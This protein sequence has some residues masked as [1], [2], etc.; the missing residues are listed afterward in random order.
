[1]PPKSRAKGRAAPKAAPDRPLPDVPVTIPAHWSSTEGINM[2]PDHVMIDKFQKLI[3]HTWRVKYTRD[4]KHGA[5]SDKCPTGAR[6][7]NVLRVE[8]HPNFQQYCN[9][10]AAIREKR[11]AEGGCPNF[12]VKTDDLL[13]PLEDDVNAMYLFH[14]TNPIAA[15]AIA[16]TDFRIDLAGSA[17]GCMF[18]P[19]LYL[20]ENA[21]KSDEYAKEGDG[22]FM[23][24]CALLVCRAVAGKV[25]TTQDKGNYQDKVLSGEFDSVCGDRLAAVGTF[26][27]MIFFG[28]A[29]VYTEYIVLYTRLF[30]E[31]P[32]K[33][34]ALAPAAV[35]APV[36]AP[37][38]PVAAAPAAPASAPAPAPAPAFPAST[39]SPTLP[40]LLAK[41]LAKIE[42]GVPYRIRLHTDQDGAE[43]QQ[44]LN[45]GKKR[46][47][48]SFFLHAVSQDPH[49]A[50]LWEF[51]EGQLEGSFNI[52]LKSDH[53]AKG[54]FMEAHRFKYGE[55]KY[56]DSTFAMCHRSVQGEKHA[57]ICRGDW[58]LEPTGVLGSF[59]LTLKSNHVNGSQG[60]CLD[61]R[62]IDKFKKDDTSCWVS[63]HAHAGG[64]WIIEQVK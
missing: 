40:A 37:P 44:Y 26:R 11:K 8:N 1:M 47:K 21:S 13:E 38:A 18:G 48:Y 33:L 25:F 57:D 61:A 35:A 14:G 32:C 51:S 50:H 30:D 59:K 22:V 12:D 54:M 6:V 15:D 31:A 36:R 46:N 28:N 23:G 29:G 39:P 17:I 9:C 63:V 16:R 43:S 55:D 2:F 7:L 5:G 56:V 10:K 60:W 20:A 64:S 45:A 19:G 58:S 62:Q 41:G 24:Q 27:E 52:K 49:D 53:S 42:M 34:P 3:T 4:R